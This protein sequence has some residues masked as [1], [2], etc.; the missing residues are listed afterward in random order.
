M[1][2]KILLSSLVLGFVVVLPVAGMNNNDNDGL[3]DELAIKTAMEISK[4]EQHSLQEHEDLSDPEL[5]RAL[6]A[7]LQQGKSQPVLQLLR[8]E[9]SRQPLPFEPEVELEEKGHLQS[10]KEAS[11]QANV[12]PSLLGKT[13]IRTGIEELF[14]EILEKGNGSLAQELLD[15]SIYEPPLKRFKKNDEEEKFSALD[16]THPTIMINNQAVIFERQHTS[17][18]DHNCLFYAITNNGENLENLRAVMGDQWVKD[19]KNKNKN[20]IDF[21][22]VRKKIYD[23]I[24]KNISVSIGVVDKTKK[25]GAHLSVSDL[26]EDGFDLTKWSNSDSFSSS[27]IITFM[28]Y[29]YK[30]NG[31]KP[32]YLAT[33][34]LFNLVTYDSF[35][36]NRF[37]LDPSIFSFNQSVDKEINIANDLFIWIAP[38]SNHYETLKLLNG[39]S[40]EPPLKRFKKN[41]EEEKKEEI[42]DTSSKNQKSIHQE[43][44]H[45]LLNNNKNLDENTLNALL[46]G[47]DNEEKVSDNESVFIDTSSSKNKK[48]VG[49]QMTAADRRATIESARNILESMQQDQ[50]VHVYTKSM[51]NQYLSIRNLADQYLAG[52]RPTDPL[53]SMGIINEAEQELNLNRGNQD[54]TTVF[55]NIRNYWKNPVDDETKQD[56]RDVFIRAYRLAKLSEDVSVLLNFKIQL[57]ENINNNGGCH[58]GVAGRLIQFYITNVL[59]TIGSQYP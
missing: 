45:A 46:D 6:A 42:I 26:F 36:E 8:Q 40:H 48:N 1:I 5:Q 13:S 22:A 17:S 27:S 53:E 24:E 2:K 25:N 44:I 34:Y 9:T 55:A 10:G 29:F 4:V 11:R 49:H 28:N 51:G 41:D 18:K 23:D 20:E 35:K 33:Y 56:L 21:K 12:S 43:V 14:N 39:S 58:A 16:I 59:S 57:A 30:N 19:N 3:D 32:I 31:L 37:I 52:F 7:S 38:G 54:L 50:D 47:E 15:D